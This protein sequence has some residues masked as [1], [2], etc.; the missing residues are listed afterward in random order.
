[1]AQQ[2]ITL[3][4]G[5][6][7]RAS[8]PSGLISIDNGSGSAVGRL[9]SGG[10]KSRV[11]PT[12]ED[13]L[14]KLRSGDPKEEKQA[15]G[16]LGEWV[17]QVKQA[18]ANY[19][20]AAANPA[21]Y[22]GTV[23]DWRIAIPFNFTKAQT[24]LA[25]SSFP[26][27]EREI[28]A[29]DA[30]GF[31]SDPVAFARDDAKLKNIISRAALR[32]IGAAAPRAAAAGAGAGAGAAAGGGGAAG[33]AAGAGPQL[34]QQISQIIANAPLSTEQRR[35]L[36]QTLLGSTQN[37][38]QDVSLTNLNDPDVRKVLAEAKAA[39]EREEK[40]AQRELSQTD[41][42]LRN[43]ARARGEGFLNKQDLAFEEGIPGINRF[44]RGQRGRARKKFPNK[45]PN[46]K[47]AL[48]DIKT[49]YQKNPTNR[50]RV[51]QIEQQRA[52]IHRKAEQASDKLI[53]Q[54]LEL[55]KDINAR[56]V[57][58]EANDSKRKFFQPVRSFVRRADNLRLEDAAIQNQ[59]G[60]LR[61]KENL[62]L[63][64]K[65]DLWASRTFRR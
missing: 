60:H 28:Q 42:E 54:R 53:K 7:L 39:A 51:R 38:R 24:N 48:Y 56:G 65:L 1:M 45:V 13:L 14:K 18:I 2:L 17:S 43:E 31:L 59:I 50:K 19:K 20:R 11:K 52:A 5:G 16:E 57:F 34:D 25:Y 22:P 15:D 47:S 64:D 3:D 12:W 30:A 32:R 63:D 44:F 26:D 46:P 8:Q 29:A 36:R 41:I 37:Q 55:F 27:A 21:A 61:A 35:E 4:A 9:P 33:G 58:R 40:K 49:A 10:L 6:F 23:T 62:S